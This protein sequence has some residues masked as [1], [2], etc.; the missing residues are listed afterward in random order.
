MEDEMMP[1]SKINVGD[2]YVNPM[3][4]GDGCEY[5]VLEK[6]EKEKMILVQSVS[7][8]T[9]EA[10]LQPFWKKNSDRIFQES[11]R[12]LKGKEIQDA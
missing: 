11:W 7:P 1:F 3:H 4:S 2:M 8:K 10:I 12:V 9:G 5:I 6:E